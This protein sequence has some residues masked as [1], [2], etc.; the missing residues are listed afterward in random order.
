M[1]GMGGSIYQHSCIPFQHSLLAI[2]EI[3]VCFIG[4]VGGGGLLG[5]EIYTNNGRIMLQLLQKV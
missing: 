3:L 4:D 5:Y 2:A 1:V